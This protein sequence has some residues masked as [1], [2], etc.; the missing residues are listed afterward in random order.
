MT[1]RFHG[2]AKGGPSMVCRMR[3]ADPRAGSIPFIKRGCCSRKA[4]AQFNVFCNV[5]VEGIYFLFFFAAFFFA[6]RRFSLSAMATAC[7]SGRPSFLSLRILLDTTFLDLPLAN[8]IMR[9]PLWK[10]YGQM[11]CLREG[12][13]AQILIGL[14]TNNPKDKDLPAPHRCRPGAPRMSGRE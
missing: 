11:P 9:F 3:F 2:H 14:A 10:T 6:L 5:I 8:G 12:F 1:A 4:S 7:F 13:Q